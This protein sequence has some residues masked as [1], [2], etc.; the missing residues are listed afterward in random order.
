MLVL[1]MCHDAVASGMKSDVTQPVTQYNLPN[2]RRLERAR[3]RASRA[4][5]SGTAAGSMKR[6]QSRD[7][8]WRMAAYGWLH[9]Q[10]QMHVRGKSR[11]VGRLENG[12]KYCRARETGGGSAGPTSERWLYAIIFKAPSR[13]IVQRSAD[14]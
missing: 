10:T 3:R 11:A 13:C 2:D 8:G 9:R 4:S 14:I 7:L 5:R 6:L 12:R 1:P